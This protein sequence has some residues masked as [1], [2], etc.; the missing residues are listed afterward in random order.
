MGFAASVTLGAIM[1]IFSPNLIG[2]FAKAS[3]GEIISI[4]SLMVRSQC[5]TMFGHTW[6]MIVNSLFQA[7][8]KPVQATIL[9]LSRQ[10]LCLIPAMLI[11]PRLWGLTGLCLA[12]AGADVLAVC[13]A[14]PMVIMFF[15]GFKNL[16]DGE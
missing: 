10:A 11:M 12:Q 9:G 16:K 4:G 2:V 14:L 13:I 5:I 3:S 7:T 6:V 1:F 15:Q 8:G